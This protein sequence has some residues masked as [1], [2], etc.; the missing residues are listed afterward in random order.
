MPPRTCTEWVGLVQTRSR[1]GAAV[2]LAVDVGPVI[3]APP[4][5]WG[6]GGG[7]QPCRLVVE[8]AACC[9]TCQHAAVGR[10]PIMA[11]TTTPIISQSAVVPSI[12]IGLCSGLLLRG[13]SSIRSSVA[14]WKHFSV[15]H[16][17]ART[18][19][20][21]RLGRNVTITVSAT[22]IESDSCVICGG[23]RTDPPA[24]DC[25]RCRFT[26]LSGKRHRPRC[27]LCGKFVPEAWAMSWA[28]RAPHPA[29][30]QTCL[31]CD[32]VLDAVEGVE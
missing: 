17:T 28:V 24:T 25:R 10:A 11:P 30:L 15:I 22:D 31:W 2:L 6:R 1:S 26:D 12:T 23:P 8:P 5:C 27:E 32:A 19:A 13:C 4:K 3:S 7:R 9:P 29:P 21:N 14:R 16:A 20:H 18:P